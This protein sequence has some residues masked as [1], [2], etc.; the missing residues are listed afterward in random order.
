MC[1]KHRARERETHACTNLQKQ[2]EREAVQC[3]RE[4]VCWWHGFFAIPGFC[5]LR[6]VV[7]LF[8]NV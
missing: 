4:R 3:V 8:L 2:R 5:V 6:I 1:E 7:D